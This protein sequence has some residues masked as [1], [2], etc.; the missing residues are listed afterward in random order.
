MTTKRD[1]L[2]RQVAAHVLGRE[3]PVR[4]LLITTRCGKRTCFPCGPVD[5]EYE[6][7]L[8]PHFGA[9][10]RSDG[11]N[12]L[13]RCSECLAAEKRFQAQRHALEL[14]AAWWADTYPPDVFDGSSGDEGPRR[15]VE[16]RE[17]LKAALE[18]SQ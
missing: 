5:R 18:V 12:D 8:C 3:E 7:N 1:P 14:V 6:P 17:A 9:R 13:C 2:I 16:I 15:V 10:L 4:G 11:V